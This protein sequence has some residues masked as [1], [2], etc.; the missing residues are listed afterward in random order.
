ME[1]KAMGWVQYGDVNTDDGEYGGDI[2]VGKAS[3]VRFTHTDMPGRLVTVYA[4][5][6]A[7]ERSIETTEGTKTTFHGYK[8]DLDSVGIQ[9]QTE[10]MVCDDIDDPGSTERWSDYRY[11]EL[12]TRP[13]TRG[14]GDDRVKAAE[15]DALRWIERFDANRDIAWD[16]EPF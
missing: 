5:P 14:D 6:T 16:G 12:D 1:K 4:Y 7:P 11:Q 9:V 13:Y 2:Q 8:H 3:H 15:V 10:F